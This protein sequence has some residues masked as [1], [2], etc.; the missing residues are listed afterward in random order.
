[1]KQAGEDH[2]LE[3]SVPE[4]KAL[5]TN[6]IYLEDQ[7]VEVM[8]IRFY[9]SPWQPMYSNSAFQRARGQE[10][11]RMWEKIPSDT[12]VLV[13]HSPPLGAGDYCYKHNADR[14]SV[15]PAGRSGCQDLMTELVE[16]IKPKYHV[17]GHVH[18]GG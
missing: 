5:L 14:V 1:M 10:L 3:M 4:V 7:A 18:E 12:Q 2:H 13:T 9:G 11:R 16:R 15:S 17:F 8:G 6:C